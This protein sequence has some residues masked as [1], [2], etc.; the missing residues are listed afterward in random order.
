M[1]RLIMK[2]TIIKDQEIWA[3]MITDKSDYIKIE[4]SPGDMVVVKDKEDKSVYVMVFLEQIIL[5][6][7]NNKFGYVDSITI[8]KNNKTTIEKMTIGYML[9]QGYRYVGNLYT[10]E[11]SL[12]LLYPNQINAILKKHN[13]RKQRRTVI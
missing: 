10:D 1:E 4:V 7:I 5:D 3:P 11:F 9:D 6:N 8:D 13:E 2:K 12:S